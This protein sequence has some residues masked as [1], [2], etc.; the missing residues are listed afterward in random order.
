MKHSSVMR[1]PINQCAVGLGRTGA[2]ALA[3]GKTSNKG[4]LDGGDKH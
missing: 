1:C 3:T 2:A 4:D